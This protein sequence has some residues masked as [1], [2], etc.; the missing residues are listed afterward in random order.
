MKDDSAANYTSVSGD[1]TMPTVAAVVVAAPTTTV[2][3]IAPTA[4][5][6][7]Y[8]FSVDID[9]RHV[10]VAVVRAKIVLLENMSVVDWLVL[11]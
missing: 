5:P 8:Q 1:G 7:G 3:V 11:H 2:E 10:L 6:A 9:G 4:L